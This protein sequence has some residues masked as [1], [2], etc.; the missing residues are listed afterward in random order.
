MSLHFFYV[1]QQFCNNSISLTSPT[2]HHSHT[3]CNINNWTGVYAPF[4]I[5]P[6]KSVASEWIH[7]GKAG[8]AQ[9]C[10]TDVSLRFWVKNRVNR[11]SLCWWS[12]TDFHPC[13]LLCISPKNLLFM[14]QDKCLLLECMEQ[15]FVCHFLLQYYF[16]CKFVGRIPPLQVIVQCCHERLSILC[17]VMLQPLSSMYFF[18]DNPYTKLYIFAKWK[19]KEWWKSSR[20]V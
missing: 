9:G 11:S 6:T 20:S 19:E 2:D 17:M 16:C 14:S 5:P 15:G 7:W 10:E 12:S 8:R 18:N 4:F 1:W 3:H 13:L